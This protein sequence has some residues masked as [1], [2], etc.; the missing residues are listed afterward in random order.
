MTSDHSKI[1]LNLHI[2][3]SYFTNESRIMR[4]SQA[5]IQLA[6]AEKVVLVGLWKE[7]LPE[8][9]EISDSISLH[10]LKTMVG[11]R[12]NSRW[13]NV[14]TL[15][16]FFMVLFRLTLRIKPQVINIH[17]LTL[18]PF[19]VLLKLVSRSYLIYDA[20]ELETETHASHGI[21][22]RVAQ[23]LERFFIKF[24]DHTIVVSHSI[25]TWYT[26]AYKLKEITT[27]KNIPQT[28]SVNKIRS[29]KSIL[30]LEETSQL[31]IYVGL[32][33]GGRGIELLLNA[34]KN[35]QGS[36]K[37]LLFLGYGDL[38]AKVKSN[39]GPNI[40]YLSA[41]P[42]HEVLEY[43]AG[44]D[45]GLSIIEKS[46]LSYYYSLPNK[47]F[48]YMAAGVPF[49]CS[50]FPDVKSEFEQFGVCWFVQSEK[51]MVELVSTLSS[52]EIKKR[53]SIVY[54]NRNNWTW[55]QEKKKL[56]GVYSSLFKFSY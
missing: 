51:E 45:V 11:K 7:G 44:A 24:V 18:L 35:L 47:V 53:K 32:L 25:E 21:R 28:T 56:K 20:H 10:R 3:P 19:G 33:S 26:H 14:F 15:L 8:R 16:S 54:Q 36:S 17:S 27:I 9:E 22:K 1:R 39:L 46:C 29:T 23:I 4:E 43:V 48:E 6:I 52:E 55:N 31:Y 49:I 37:H 42:P 41:V 40:H 5:I 12:G 50:D 13:S 38:V 2:Y 30:G 34:F